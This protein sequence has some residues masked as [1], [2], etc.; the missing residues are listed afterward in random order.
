MIDRPQSLNRHPNGIDGMS[1]YQKDV[2][3]KVPD[4]VVTH[5]D[6]SESNKET[7]EYFVCTNEA[8]L[9]Y[10]ANLGCIEMNPWHSRTQSPDNPDYCLIDLDPYEIGFDKVI[11]TARIVK[12]ILDDLDIPGYCKTSGSTGIHI[13]I[14]LGAKYDYDQSKN[15]AQLLVTLVHHE[16]PAFTSLERNPKK[17]KRKIYLDFLQNRQSQTVAAPYSLRPKPGA[18]VSTPLFWEEVRKGLSPSQFTIKNILDRLKTEGDIFTPVL[19][20]GIDLKKTLVKIES[21]LSLE[22]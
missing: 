8:S 1:F 11:E 18:T 15:L 4:W 16:I 5:P 20:K 7:I 3:G 12:N 13:F 21:V 19:Q 2:R 22:K 17:R 6:Y 10:L 9:L 14:P